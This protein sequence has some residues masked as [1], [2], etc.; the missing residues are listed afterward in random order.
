MGILFSRRRHRSRIT[1][2]DKAVLNLKRQRDKLNQMTKKLDNQIENDL[3]LAKELVRQGKK[4]R[5]LLLLKKKKY[6]ENLIHNTNNQLSNIE[7]LINDI[8]FAQIE[9][10]VLNGLKCGN[11]AL[12]DIQ[13]VL[14][15]DDAEQIMSEAHE[16][17]EYQRDLNNIVSSGLSNND[18]DEIELELT[19]LVEPEVINL[20]SVP[21]HPIE[22][23][24]RKDR[25]KGVLIIE[26]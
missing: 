19:R 1:E 3:G 25:S 9:V 15:L 12:Q 2:Q 6:L 26:G 8:E 4:E 22:D 24:A 14:S 5:A 20:P 11:K 7:Q 16:A 21:D 17:I 10:E 23:S 18:Y 13:K